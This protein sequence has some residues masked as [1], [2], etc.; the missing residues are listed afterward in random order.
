MEVKNN[1]AGRLYDIL[2]SVRKQ[3]P[4]EKSRIAWANV[5]EID[6]NDN[7]LLLKM[8]SDVIDLVHETKSSIIILNDI[9]HE[10]YLEPFDKIENFVSRIQFLE[11][12]WENWRNNIDDV[13]LVR[14]QFI[15]DKLSRTIGYTKIP[16]DDIIDLRTQIDKLINDATDSS[17]PHELKNLLLRN[18]DAVRYALLSY[19][20][21]G[22]GRL[23]EEMER[24]IGSVL[25]HKEEIK[26]V[27]EKPNEGKLWKRFWELIQK[28]NSIVT[29]AKNS[30]DIAAPV[31]LSITENFQS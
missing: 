30:K 7:S 13:T 29:L 21:R 15:D 27:N 16:N 11:S 25:L 3:N 20:I 17:L 10:L 19:S 4:K 22:I 24:S 31:I 26:S 5:F 2:S 9:N 12:A 18:L 6:P 14:L 28:I 23:H 1:P 8:L